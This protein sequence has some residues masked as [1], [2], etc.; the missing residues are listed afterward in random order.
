MGV[1]QT[2]PFWSIFCCSGGKVKSFKRQELVLLQPHLS[3]AGKEG[4][5]GYT[6]S[7]TGFG[8]ATI[9]VGA[10]PSSTQSSESASR[11]LTCSFCTTWKPHKKKLKVRATSNGL[12]ASSWWDF[13]PWEKAEWS[14]LKQTQSW[15]HSELSW[16]L[17][18]QRPFQFMLR[19]LLITCDILI[20]KCR[21]H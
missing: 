7:R 4:C 18:G 6:L 14:R 16:Q 15:E 2:F 10:P 19:Y 13:T 8:T 1:F 9:R 17:F 3:V 5:A 20:C 11:K 12:P 21:L